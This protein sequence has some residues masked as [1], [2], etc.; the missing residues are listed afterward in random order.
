MSDIF[1]GILGQPHVRAFLRSSICSSHISHAYLFSGPIGSNKTSAALAFAQAIILGSSVYD[2]KDKQICD[3]IERHVHPDVQFIYPEGSRGYLIS[4]IRDIVADSLLAPIQAK[5]KV[6]ILDRI[7]LLGT[8][9]ANAFLKTLEEPASYITFILLGRTSESVLPTI[10][11]RCQIIPFRFIPINEA[12]GIVVQNTGVDFNLARIAID[13][14]NG[15]ITNAIK[16]VKR[17]E[18]IAFRQRVVEIFSLLPLADDFDVLNYAKELLSLCKLPIDSLRNTQI[19]ELESNQDFLTNVS[20]KRIEERNKRALNSASMAS[21][22]QLI[23]IIRSL[24][25]DIL[26]IFSNC[27]SLIVNTDI[28]NE[29]ELLSKQI[30]LKD[31][32]WLLAE[33]DSTEVALSYNVSPE[34]CIDTLLINIRKVIHEFDNAHKATSDI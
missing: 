19:Q 8:E 15:S 10:V 32:M 5:R 27:V 24:L 2:N 23:S 18:S 11:S 6:Y 12:I 7:D 9:A 26:M 17:K 16:F 21:L 1:D 25:R 30:K 31:L 4:Q 14:C 34:L 29:L 33:T 13:A 20:K 3:A 28:Y 22:L